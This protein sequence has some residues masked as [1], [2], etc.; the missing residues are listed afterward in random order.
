MSVDYKMT[1][2]FVEEYN[3]DVVMREMQCNENCEKVGNV[4]ALTLA[5]ITGLA[6][7]IAFIILCVYRNPLAI[8]FGGLIVVGVVEFTIIGVY[9][10]YF[11]RLPM[12]EPP[13]V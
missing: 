3:Y 2:E 12:P 5:G 7:I 9:V 10:H 13:Q 11:E 8:L 6:I 1:K 4:F